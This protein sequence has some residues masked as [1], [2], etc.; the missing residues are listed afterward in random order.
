MVYSDSKRSGNCKLLQIENK[1]GVDNFQDKQ[2]NRQKRVRVFP[3]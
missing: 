1:S 3:N 2:N